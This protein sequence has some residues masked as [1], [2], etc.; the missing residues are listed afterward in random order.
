MHSI[1]FQ[2]IAEFIRLHLAVRD[3]RRTSNSIA[4]RYNEEPWSLS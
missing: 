3:N 4:S 2:I 1:E